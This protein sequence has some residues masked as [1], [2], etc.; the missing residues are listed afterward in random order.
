MSYFD[1]KQ[2]FNEPVV[3]QHSSHM[4]MK[5]IHKPEKTSYIT[6]DST[7]A[8]N[9]DLSKNV[10]M[11][12]FKLSDP[13]QE[14]KELTIKTATI[15]LSWYNISENLNNSFFSVSVY[16]DD[17]L[18]TKHVIK[19][20]DNEYLEG[21]LIE[22][23][24]TKISAII[25][26]PGSKKPVFVVPGN[27]S[28]PGVKIT[29]DNSGAGSTYHYIIDFI[30]DKYGNS[31]KRNPK[32]KLGYQLGFRKP[33]YNTKNGDIEAEKFIDIEKRLDVY[34]SLEDFTT[35]YS[36]NYTLV[37]PDGQTRDNIIAKIRVDPDDI[38]SSK[39]YGTSSGNTENEK[40]ENV[41]HKLRILS[42]SLDT[43]VS[44]TRLYS[45]KTTIQKFKI[46]LKDKF[47]NYIDLNGLDFDITMEIKHL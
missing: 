28:K 36:S 13:I 15:P 22:K 2:L 18:T 32:S 37:K 5:N 44:G 1:G 42:S 47:G 14:V 25:T 19:V 20:D 7:F 33:S 10:V 23:I 9:D 41:Y 34:L 29:V 30:V 17:T 12:D 46:I 27:S 38:D 4:I 43:I 16:K 3:E 45:G 39:K 21:T 6:L 26:E 40:I 35:G 24:N 8:I 11:W 31:D